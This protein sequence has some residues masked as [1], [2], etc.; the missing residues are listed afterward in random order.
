MY[1]DFNFRRSRKIYFLFSDNSLFCRIFDLFMWNKF[2]LYFLTCKVSTCRSVIKLFISMLAC[3]ARATDKTPNPVWLKTKNK[4]GHKIKDIR[5]N[6]KIFFKIQL[7]WY[8]K[9]ILKIYFSWV[10]DKTFINWMNIL[11]RIFLL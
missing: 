9:C 1:K 8:F 6:W 3:S 5:K 11:S 7:L 4:A 2:S 10:Y